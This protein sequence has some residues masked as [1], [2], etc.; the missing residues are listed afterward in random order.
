[1]G[2]WYARF[3]SKEGF[4]V[5]ITGRDR[6]KLE[7]A[8]AELGVPVAAN[9]EAA[10]S[11]EVVLLSV[12]ID[13][14]EEAVKEIA[15]VINLGQ[16]IMDITSIKQKPI[17]LMHQYFPGANILGTHPVF[18]PGARDPGSQNFVLTPTNDQEWALAQKVKRFLEARSARVALMSP[19]E[20]DEM[21][22]VVLGLAHFISIVA[23]D[24]LASL[25]R[26]PQMKAIG[27]STYRV[28]TTLVESVISEDP[29]LYATLQM[30]LP[31]LAEI[32]KLFQKNAARWA[33]Y[34]ENRNKPAF[35]EHMTALKLK[36][37]ENNSN[38]GQ[39]YENMYK[40]MEWL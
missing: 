6:T 19:A 26:L 38:F 7:A 30:H 17:D 1:M 22:S 5:I 33:D 35:K 12:A 39:A 32:E 31:G 21:M 25:N 40:I 13:N 11:S 36:F 15:P 10:K 9:T 28:L 27:G 16:V 2:K 29:E 23:A 37:T 4:E 20:H 8:G 3:L 18:G 24:T 14:F 34:T